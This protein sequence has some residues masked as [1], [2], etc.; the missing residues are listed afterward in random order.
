MNPEKDEIY[1]KL[2]MSKQKKDIQ[3]NKEN[4]YIKLDRMELTN[5]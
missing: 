5:M 3:L 4:L 2:I 1:S